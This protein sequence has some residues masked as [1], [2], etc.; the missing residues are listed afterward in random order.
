MKLETIQFL[1]NVPVQVALHD[2]KGL[3]KQGPKGPKVFLTTI[4]G[5][6]MWLEPGIVESIGNLQVAPGES[7]WICKRRAMGK[8][9]VM[10]DLW[11]GEAKG[12]VEQNASREPLEAALAR[13]LD[14]VKGKTLE[15]PAPVLEPQETQGTG[16]YGPVGLPA[17]PRRR[18]M[19]IPLNVALMEILAFVTTG[20]KDSGEQWNDAAKQD[21]VSTFIIEAGK[22]GYTTL[23]ER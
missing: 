2:L 13:S 11:K 4:D 23:W 1:T 14:R 12:P 16:T 6:S 17:T 9:K 18:S 22:R 7:F 15:M 20:L 19:P 8:R 10:W 5:R 3:V 21:L